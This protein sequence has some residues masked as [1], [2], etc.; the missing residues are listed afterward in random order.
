MLC[1]STAC[2]ATCLE[3]IPL[4]CH[5]GWCQPCIV[6]GKRPSLAF[7]STH[8]QIKLFKIRSVNGNLVRKFLTKVRNMFSLLFLSFTG[9]I[10]LLLLP[11]SPLSWQISPLQPRLSVCRRRQR[12]CFWLTGGA[13]FQR[14]GTRNSSL[15][16]GL[17]RRPAAFVTCAS[18]EAAVWCQTPFSSCLLGSPNTPPTHAPAGWE[19]VSPGGETRRTDEI[20][21]E[22]W[23][24]VFFFVL[25][26]SALF[27]CLFF[28]FFV[29]A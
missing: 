8:S 5:Q 2:A 14:G 16:L 29:K 26:C 18:E 20:F 11:V 10:F 13:R 21:W 19:A 23:K 22:I 4:W 12:V 1:K 9:I 28:F 7:G 24:C 3:F 15:W 27:V 17:G 25:N 6:S